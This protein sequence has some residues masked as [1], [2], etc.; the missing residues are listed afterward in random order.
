MK[1]WSIQQLNIER[2]KDLESCHNQLERDCC[3]AICNKEMM[4]IS[5]EKVTLSPGDIAILDKLGLL[6]R[7]IAELTPK[8]GALT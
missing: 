7:V 2:L 5:I 1:S 8:A 6:K 4:Q 3:N